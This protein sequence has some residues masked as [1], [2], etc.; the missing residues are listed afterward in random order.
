MSVQ[1][2]KQD[3]W[4]FAVLLL[5]AVLVGIAIGKHEP[6]AD[7]AHVWLLAR[8]ASFF[9]LFFHWL[10]FEG[11]PGLWCLILFLPAKLGAPY[12]TMNIISGIIAMVTVYLFLQ[13]SPFPIYVNILLPFSYFFFYQYA[14]VARNYTL[15]P[16]LLVLLA[17]AYRKKM[18]H[19]YR[20]IAPLCL[21][22]YASLHTTLIAIGV[23]VV[24]AIDMKKHWG[25]LA[26]K[27]KRAQLI[28]YGIF[29]AVLVLIA[30]QHW[31]RS[32]NTLM[33]G[34]NLTLKQFALT[35]RRF[36]IGSGSTLTSIWP[37]TLIVLLGS[38]VWFWQKKT[39][40][41]FLLPSFLVYLLV[42]AKPSSIFNTGMFFLIWFFAM[43][44]SF[45]SHEQRASFELKG[46][47]VMKC[48]AIVA[49]LLILVVQVFWGLK[50]FAFDF[51]H[52]YAGSAAVALYI[53]DNNLES[54]KIYMVSSAAIG[55][56]PYFKNNI[57]AN[58]H[59]GKKPSFWLYQK[60]NTT[61]IHFDEKAQETILKNR[62]DF[63]VL[64]FR[65]LS[66]EKQL[67]DFL[68]KSGYYYIGPFEGDMIWKGKSYL[69]A[70]YTY[71]ILYDRAKFTP[72]SQ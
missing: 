44:V 57:F 69:E 71:L 10:H 9:R 48:I 38:L 25:S 19:P 5:F 31:P 13:Y 58:Y 40:L 64:P 21:L 17:V 8:D 49:L 18:E 47:A 70:S 39:L 11:H 61:P 29:A 16:L 53:K 67:T 59:D 50:A 56:L 24:H 30:V 32:D 51:G 68:A 54:R 7:E 66:S 65:A 72:P 12:V 28:S 2:I 33:L 1:N 41:L 22:A 14:V 20:F 26:L 45:D 42:S 52:P 15:A 60:S 23:I 55:I 34:F 46:D 3:W 63:V 4:K 35:A 27:L 62:P 6:F 43:W 36:L 37:L